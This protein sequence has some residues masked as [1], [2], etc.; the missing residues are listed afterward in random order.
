[1]V[2]PI[3]IKVLFA[4]VEAPRQEKTTWRMGLLGK[5]TKFAAIRRVRMTAVTRQ[6][7]L[8]VVVTAVIEVRA[9]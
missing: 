7:R 2:M 9:T 8:F 3:E 6:T 5:R 1:L 4:E